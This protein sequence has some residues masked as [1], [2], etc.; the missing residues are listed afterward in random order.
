M[1]L[2][3]TRHIVILIAL[4]VITGC[5]HIGP[6][7]ILD[8]RIPYNEAIVTSWKQQTLLN[9]V[10]L[11]YLDVPEFVDVP[12]MVNGYE[13]NRTT[14][15]SFG[16]EVH[17]QDHVAN[18]LTFG[19]SGSRTMSDRPTVTYSPQTGSQFTRNLTNPLPPVSIL[20]L[21]ESG[22]PADVVMELAVESI[23][24]IRNR[25]FVGGKMQQGDP[26][27]YQ[28]LQNISK[29]QA[30]GHVS[31]RVKPGSDK[32]HP[33]ILLTI[34]DRDIPPAL[35]E[36]LAQTR[37]LLRL[38]PDVHEFKVV[39]GMLPESND[40]I[41]FRTRSV[42]RIM[43]FPALNV[44]VPDNHL[45]DGRALD[46]GDAGST[47]QPQL[48]VHS[49]CEKPCDDDAAVQYQGFW[50][51]IDHRDFH[52]KRSMGYLKILLALADTGPREAAPALTIRANSAASS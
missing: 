34:Q 7:T 11:R 51:W 35:A 44:Q 46:L 52:S 41:A 6:R 33:D 1:K 39:F 27:F 10:R 20:N 37:K 47:T 3:R 13:H 8:D 19:L 28:V 17:P 49:G 12:S 30:S 14:S 38:D 45:A 29:A 43:T 26:E 15:G 2:S 36:E 4:L 22:T 18:F 21:I 48:T 25:Q 5:Q 24:G 32:E 16:A 23:N 50:F 31:L 42:L 40:E 9:I